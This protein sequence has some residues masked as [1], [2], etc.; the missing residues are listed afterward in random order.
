MSSLIRGGYTAAVF[1]LELTSF[2]FIYITDKYIS[3]VHMYQSLALR[4][5]NGER[6]GECPTSSM[7]NPATSK[8]NMP[9]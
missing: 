3:H 1:D 7:H 4:V 9:A 2:F 8:L 5:C 6:V